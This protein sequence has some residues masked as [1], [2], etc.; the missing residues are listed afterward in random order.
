MKITSIK[1][2][3]NTLEKFMT[4]IHLTLNTMIPNIRLF[5]GVL[6]GTFAISLASTFA[7][8][9]ATAQ[10]SSPAPETTPSQS[11]QPEATPPAPKQSSY[12]GFGGNIGIQ[13]S[14]T[15]LSQGTFSLL[16]KRVLTDNLAIHSANTIFGSSVTSSSVALTFNQ[17]ISSQ[18]LPIVFIPFLGAGVIVH[19]ENGTRINPL[20]T[21]GID[22]STPLDLTGTLRINAGFINNRQADIGIL[23]GVGKNY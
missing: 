21:G 5:V 3:A 17:P 6:V 14:T 2:A 7:I 20:I 4:G 23:F 1:L 9:T 19:H 15:S 8:P 11:P 12:F 22:A 10:P 18:D 16:S 13:G